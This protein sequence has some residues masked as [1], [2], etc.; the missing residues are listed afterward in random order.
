MD[1]S[2]SPSKQ[3]R[4]ACR[5]CVD[6]RDLDFWFIQDVWIDTKTIEAPTFVHDPTDKNREWSLFWSM[7]DWVVSLCSV[8]SAAVEALVH[9]PP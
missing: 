5:V 4:R 9:H 2:S 8:S 6:G 7:T 3:R 1:A